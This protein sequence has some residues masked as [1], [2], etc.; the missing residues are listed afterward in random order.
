MSLD[1]MRFGIFLAPFHTMDENPT[2]CID[3]DM[4][5]VCHLDRLDYDEAWIG[6]H[7]SGGFEIISSPEIFCAVAAERTRS[8]RLG[9]GVISLPYHNPFMVA[10]RVAQL[11]HMLRGRF[12]FG[13][14]PGALAGDAYRM[15][16]DPEQ[17]R[18]M[19]HEAIDVIMPL[20]RGELVNAETDWFKLQ[21]ARL[22]LPMY[23]EGGPTTAVASSRSPTGALAAGRHGVGMLSIGGTSD[24]ALAAHA[25]N[26]ETCEETAREHGQTVSR[27][28]WRMVTL[29]HVAETRQKARENVEFGLA[30]W[31][32]YFSDVATFPIIP[33]GIDKPIEYLIESKS[34]LIGTPDDAIEFIE[35]LLRGSGGF[36]AV[37]Q[38][39]H[40][41]A[42][43]EQTKRSYELIARYVAPH[44]RKSNVLR[45][46]SYDYST[47]N[48]EKFVNAAAKSVEDAIKNYEAKS[49]KEW[50]NPRGQQTKAAE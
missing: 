35:H 37:M 10:N 3:R 40:N 21:D 42:D 44:F 17:Q 43:W 16:V 13:F 12:M 2:L 30:R 48:R 15:G 49:G 25:K 5:L 22:Q 19:M 32:K 4:E 29:M 33:P 1:H 46:F 14:G 36:G 34:A 47:E 24:A 7:H 50:T 9:S 18:R 38:L 11:D 23:T 39:A 26:W 20:L 31:T 27:D 8:I 28:N 41:W 45:Q 6:E